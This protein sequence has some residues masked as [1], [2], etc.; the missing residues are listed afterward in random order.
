MGSVFSSK[1]QRRLVWRTGR[2]ND[3]T[4]T[5]DFEYWNCG[6]PSSASTR[7]VDPR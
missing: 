7:A 6:P 5:F 1:P 4:K 2:N 3:G